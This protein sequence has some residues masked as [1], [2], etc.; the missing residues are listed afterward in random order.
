[1]LMELTMV[2]M[3]AAMTVAMMEPLMAVMLVDL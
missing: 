1:M 3:K 2:V